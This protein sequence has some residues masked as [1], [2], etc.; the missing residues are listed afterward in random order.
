MYKKFRGNIFAA[1]ARLNCMFSGRRRA[2][3]PVSLRVSMSGRWTWGVI[4]LNI[5]PDEALLDSILIPMRR[6]IGRHARPIKSVWG[7]SQAR[8]GCIP[9]KRHWSACPSYQ[10]CYWTHIHHNAAA[11]PKIAVSGDQCPASF[12]RPSQATNAQPLTNHA[13]GV[14]DRSQAARGGSPASDQPCHWCT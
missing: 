12:F 11:N 10:K 9:S 14:C 3:P 2:L 6:A 7:A 5:D 8:L 13:I 4:G 1:K